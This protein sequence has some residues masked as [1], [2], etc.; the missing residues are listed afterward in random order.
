MATLLYKD[1]VQIRVEA[2][3]VQR[4]LASGYSVTASTI[5]H[6]EPAELAEAFEVSTAEP[7]KNSQTIKTLG[8]R[9]R[10]PCSK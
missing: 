8:K 9:G 1:G 7:L 10:K 4:L 3:K 5:E 6:I 2:D